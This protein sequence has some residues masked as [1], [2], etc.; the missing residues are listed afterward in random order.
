M[1][2]K[3][4]YNQAKRAAKKYPKAAMIISII[5]V[6]V[7]ASIAIFW[8]LRPDIFHI[9][10]GTGSHVWS[11]DGSD[12]WEVASEATCGRKGT[13][14]RKCIYCNEEQSEKIPATNDH[15]FN[16]DNI[17]IKCGFDNNAPSVE[18]VSNSELSI[19]FI[20][21]GNANAG[22]CTLIKCGDTEVLIDAGSKRNSTETVK[23]YIN[24][25]CTD[26]ILEYVIATHAHEDH[27]AAL[28]GE[29][30]KD[31][32]VLYSYE[33]GTIIQFAGHKTDSK[34]YND[35][36]QAV[37][38]AEIKGTSVYTAKQCWYETDGAKKT[39]YLDD[40][41]KI[42]LNILY[43]KYYD[44]NT[45]TENNYSVCTLLS[46]QVSADVTN[47]YLFTGD[48]EKAG[49]ESLVAKNNLPECVLFKGGHHGSST[50]SNDKL[51]KV[52]KPENIAICSCAGTYE[53]ADK[54]SASKPESQAKLNTFP[55]QEAID[56]MAKYTKNIYVTTLGILNEDYSTARYESMNGNIVFYSTGGQLKLWCSNNDTILKETAWFK[57]NRTWPSTGIK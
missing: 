42:S 18:N 43:Q 1:A 49:E 33:I 47:N 56:R 40:E 39:Y 8:V 2:N 29:E 57:A 24:Q 3:N 35:Y 15:N 23:N 27:I 51:L 41:N 55:T 11:E 4:T 9:Y 28:V 21:L 26:G 46:Q 6:I 17:C 22:D 31:N 34:V 52:I 38:A 25:Y 48:L 50:S 5:L 12:G 7:I 16:G 54:P 19:H 32:G 20:E 30:G 53:Y 37:V 36:V 44:Q 13:K 14:K 10:I 45:S